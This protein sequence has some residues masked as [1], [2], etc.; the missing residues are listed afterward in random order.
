MPK[1]HFIAM[2]RD[3]KSH[4]MVL[5]CVMSMEFN[6]DKKIA[7]LEIMKLNHKKM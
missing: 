7:G 3:P 6:I 2:V 5:W 1:Q 4:A